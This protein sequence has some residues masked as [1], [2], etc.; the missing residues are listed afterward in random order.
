VPDER[1]HAEGGDRDTLPARQHLH[2]IQS[3]IQVVD[4]C[5]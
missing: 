3:T 1:F 5:G 4:G 2:E